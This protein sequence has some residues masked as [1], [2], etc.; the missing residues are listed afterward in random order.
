MTDVVRID[1]LLDGHVG[2][3]RVA[4]EMVPVGIGQSLRIDKHHQ[5]FVEACVLIRLHL[6]VERRDH[7]LRQAG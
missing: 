7:D 3:V 4:D 2:E 5:L 6:V 1:K